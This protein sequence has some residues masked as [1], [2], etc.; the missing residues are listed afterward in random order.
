MLVT[1]I[2][3][4]LSLIPSLLLFL[5]SSPLFPIPSSA[6]DDGKTAYGHREDRIRASPDILEV[7]GR[8]DAMGLGVRP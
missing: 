8:L 7:L 3:F 4:L 6:T 5:L 1:S 2:F